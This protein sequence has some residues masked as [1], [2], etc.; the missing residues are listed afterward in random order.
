MRWNKN[1]TQLENMENDHVETENECQ[2]LFFYIYK[3]DLW[4]QNL[5]VWK[6]GVTL[7]YGQRIKNKNITIGEKINECL[8]IT[9]PFN[10]VVTFTQNTTSS[11]TPMPGLQQFNFSYSLTGLVIF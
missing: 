9:F 7:F 8:S 2:N 10:L 4:K 6:K 5:R 3:S 11:N 1:M